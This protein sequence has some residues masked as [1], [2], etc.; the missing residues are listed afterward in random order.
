[1]S[2]KALWCVKWS[3]VSSRDVALRCEVLCNDALS[4]REEHVLSLTSSPRRLQHC[5]SAGR[6]PQHNRVRRRHEDVMLMSISF[7]ALL[8]ASKMCLS[9]LIQQKGCCL[10]VRRGGRPVTT[11]TTTHVVYDRVSEWQSLTALK[12]KTSFLTTKWET[13]YR[14]LSCRSIQKRRLWRRAQQ[15][16]ILFWIMQPFC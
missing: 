15:S 8:F 4:S 13:W 16:C 5:L 10:L 11:T 9:F 6:Q 14:T 3:A 2:L 7:H 1:M 12:C